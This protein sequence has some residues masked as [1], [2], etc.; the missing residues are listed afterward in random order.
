MA[1]IDWDKILEELPQALEDNY[2]D[3]VPIYSYRLR[4]S[5]AYA[6]CNNLGVL[7]A[8]YRTYLIMK[9]NR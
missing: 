2:R 3:T 4:N 7:Q 6:I 8:L 9:E 5:A 1:N